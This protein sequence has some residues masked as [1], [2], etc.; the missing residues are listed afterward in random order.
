MNSLSD[1]QIF[2]VIDMES[3]GKIFYRLEGEIHIPS[4]SPQAINP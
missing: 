3:K 2:G 4:W 1:N